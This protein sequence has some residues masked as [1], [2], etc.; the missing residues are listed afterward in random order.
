VDFSSRGAS[1]CN[2]AN[3]KHIINVYKLRV[4]LEGDMFL[5]VVGIGVEL[6]LELCLVTKGDVYL[7]LSDDF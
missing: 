6:E 5:D 1:D 3:A 4:K 7:I 2:R